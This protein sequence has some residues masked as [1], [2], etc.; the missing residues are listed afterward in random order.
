MKVP[1]GDDDVAAVIQEIE[2]SIANWSLTARP[3]RA[4]SGGDESE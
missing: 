2:E 3:Q 1:S 4:E